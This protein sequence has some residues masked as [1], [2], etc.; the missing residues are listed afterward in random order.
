VR[1][2]RLGAIVLLYIAPSL[3]AQSSTGVVRQV[4]AEP[5]PPAAAVTHDNRTPAGTTV[6]TIRKLRLEVVNSIWR[7][8][9]AEG[10]VRDVY[11]F[12]VEGG[13]PNIPGPLL[14]VREG[15]EVHVSVRNRIARTVKMHGLVPRPAS[16]DQSVDI[17][18]G[19]A[20]EF[21]FKVGA[22]GT[23]YYWARTSDSAF[24]QRTGDDSQLTGALIVDASNAEPDADR[25]FV[26][27]EWLGPIPRP[28]TPR[29][30]SLVMNGRSWPQ[31][32]RLAIP[33]GLAVE[34][35]IINASAAPHPMHLH[36]TFYTV[37]SRGTAMRDDVYGS[38]NR[39]LVTTELM[40]PGTTMMMRWVPDRVGNWLFHCHFLAHVTG[41]MRDGDAAPG[42]HEEHA[43]HD[44]S[45]AMA[46]L[47]LGITVQPGDE[48]AAPDLETHVRRR[49]TLQVRQTPD[50]YGSNPAYGFTLDS[51]AS[52]PAA[53]YGPGETLSPPI[54]LTRGEPVVVGVQNAIDGP[55]AIHWHGIELESFN[56]G[57]P[58]W[59][60]YSTQI[61]PPVMPGQTFDVNFTPPRAGTFIYH[62][63]G[64]DSRQ[65]VSGM[66]GALVVVEPGTRFDPAVDN[67]VLLGGNGPGSP[68]L[69]MNR[70]T[71]PA[72]KELQA[73][74]KH[75]FRIINIL[76]NGNLQV[77]LRGPQ[78]PVQ[79][80]AVAKD[81]ADLPPNQATMRPATLTISVGETYDFE[82]EPTGPGELRLEGLRAGFVTTTLLR[83]TR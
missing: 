49:M 39:R 37:E 10:P 65:L 70:S 74:V 23:Y 24:A 59:S 32:E 38:P 47:V 15:T 58:G 19:K 6:G 78:G 64:H 80:R 29:K 46:G 77:T 1:T 8:E 79:W 42:A 43:E 45:K 66:Y 83:V 48:T 11:A 50:R 54:I 75:R 69:E 71:N 3:P 25:I 52:A 5:A 14:R 35:R 20:L 56:D 82:Y 53:P 13:E 63:H 17:L 12:A 68:A 81:G 76:T 7:P 72:P 28:G 16:S 33:F 61:M 26:M 36:G 62:T 51:A 2:I 31:T 4:V 27:S 21:R 57:V 60:G 34:W 9:G 22:P 40:M 41:R 67:I 44:L 55:I 30:V 18:P 73:G